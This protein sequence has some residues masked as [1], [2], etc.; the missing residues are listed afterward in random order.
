MFKVKVDGLKEID[1]SLQQL[2]K[3]TAKNVVR[4][5]LKKSAK[6]IQRRAKSLAPVRTGTLRDSIF[7]STKLSKAREKKR[8]GPGDIEIFIG[9]GGPGAYHAHLQEFGTEHHPPTPFLRP[10]W[11]S[12]KSSILDD[13]REDFWTEVKKAVERQAKKKAKGK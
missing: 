12:F 13:I 8:F 10:A 5:I 3:A 4:R 2:P 1:K 9:A 11:D 6:P 7:V